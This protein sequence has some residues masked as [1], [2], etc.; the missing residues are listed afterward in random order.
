M[1]RHGQHHTFLHA[2]LPLRLRS[3]R[4]VSLVEILVAVGISSLLLA[5][6]S[7][8]NLLASQTSE[9]GTTY[10]A[11]HA[12][13]RQGIDW[14][15]QDIRW[16]NQ[17]LSSITIS[18]TLYTTADDT[19]VLEIPS[20]DSSGNVIAETNDYVVYHLNSE[21][22]TILER[23]LDAHEDSSRSDATKTIA[24][25]VSALGFSANGT[26]LAS[27]SDVTVLSQVEIALTTQKTAASGKLVNDSLNS[28][29]DFRN[30]GND[31]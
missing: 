18:S 1:P 11:T 19:I 2:K 6:V 16:A 24:Q 14:M 29:I 31:S 13:T 5:S 15:T 7:T 9:Y 27:V 20:I 21:D 3:R 25:N 4:G 28:V 8:I 26:G 30:K 17:I 22:N 10:M 12:G 23:I